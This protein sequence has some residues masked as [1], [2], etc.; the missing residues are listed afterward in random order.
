VFTITPDHLKDFLVE[1]RLTQSDFASLLDVSPRA[2]TFWLAGKRPIPGPI[3]AFA[4]LWRLL[5]ERLRQIEIGRL[6]KGPSVREGI[7]AI[8]FQSL[9]GGAGMG[10]LIFNS[11]RI[12]G[13]DIAGVKYDG[14]YLINEIT[15]YVTAT[16]KIT[17]APNVESIFGFSNPYEWAFDVTATFD[18]MQ[19]TGAM[20]VTT[21]IGQTVTAQYAFL[22]DLPDAA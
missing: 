11:G 16:I 14:L 7:Y 17:F 1:A 4:R 3:A 13:A 18:P 21:S 6:R 2:V 10:T 19:L 12:F 20:V 22:R 9:N 8:G 5:P 15:G